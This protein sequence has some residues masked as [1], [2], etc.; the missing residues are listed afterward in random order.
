MIARASRRARRWP[1]NAAVY[2]NARYGAG[3]VEA[4]IQDSYFN[5]LEVIQPHMHIVRRAEEAWR[6]VG[7]EPFSE[8]HSRRHGRRAALV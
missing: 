3:T 5:M 6:A 4:D 2:L 8:S 7:V 1:A